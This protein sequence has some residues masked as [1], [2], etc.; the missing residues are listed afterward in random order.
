MKEV[1]SII[2]GKVYKNCLIDVKDH[3]KCKEVTFENCRFCN[4]LLKCQTVTI[5]SC[6]GDIDLLES[7]EGTISDSNIYVDSFEFD[8]NV[9]KCTLKI[10]YAFIHKIKLTKSY[11]TIESWQQGKIKKDD[12]S[13]VYFT[14]SNISIN[15]E[16]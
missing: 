4:L 3:V 13:Q 7:E 16:D 15:N 11:L 8:G 9:K 6:D 2:D 1:N 5:I 12:D 14:S 10:V